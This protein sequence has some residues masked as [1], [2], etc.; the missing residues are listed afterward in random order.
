M[1][2][3]ALKD[4]EEGAKATIAAIQWKSQSIDEI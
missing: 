2:S 4:L 1:Y 3:K